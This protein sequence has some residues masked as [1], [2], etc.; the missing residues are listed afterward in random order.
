MN[1]DTT[2]RQKLANRYLRAAD[3]GTVSLVY[4]IGFSLIYYRDGEIVG[5]PTWAFLP[6]LLMLPALMWSVAYMFFRRKTDEF[7]LAMWHSGVTVAF[8]VVIAWSIFGI[9]VESTIE[10]YLQGDS[11][12]EVSFDI[13]DNW[14]SVIILLG[15]YVGF[16]FKR[17]TGGM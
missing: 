15:Y 13:V 6:L 9:M 11:G 5:D 3:I 12:T 7:T 16:H 10:G 1:A 8:F 14:D 17:F 2:M 4:L